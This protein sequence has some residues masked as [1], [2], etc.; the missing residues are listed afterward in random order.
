[1]SEANAWRVAYGYPPAYQEPSWPADDLHALQ[2]A[3]AAGRGV[4]HRPCWTQRQGAAR[5]HTRRY[6]SDSPST[7]ND[8]NPVAAAILSG[9]SRRSGA[10]RPRA[11][12]RSQNAGAASWSTEYESGCCRLSAAVT[13][14]RYIALRL[15]ANSRVSANRKPSSARPRT[16]GCAKGDHADCRAA[17]HRGGWPGPRPRRVRD[18]P[19]ERDR[20]RP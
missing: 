3:A 2:R 14:S 9:I 5:F 10:V 1:M 17:R 4:R 13:R 7:A 6:A 18:R 12:R 11:H 8:L 20:L 19:R 15:R 16:G